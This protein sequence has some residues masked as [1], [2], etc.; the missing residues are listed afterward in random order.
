[1]TIFCNEIVAGKFTL[2]NYCMQCDI[3]ENQTDL[4]K[5]L[6]GQEF[7]LDLLNLQNM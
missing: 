5:V 2:F 4:F 3:Y 1:M 6:P 7:L